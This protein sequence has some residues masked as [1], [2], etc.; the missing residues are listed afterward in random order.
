LIS[1]IRL[2]MKYIKNFFA[3]IFW[4]LIYIPTSIFVWVILLKDVVVGRK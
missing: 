4:I 1:S 2:I 3:L